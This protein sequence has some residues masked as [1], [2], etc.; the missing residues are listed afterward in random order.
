MED[1]RIKNSISEEQLSNLFTECFVWEPR[2]STL[3]LEK[4]SELINKVRLLDW[5]IEGNLTVDNKDIWAY[6]WM[7]VDK[8]PYEFENSITYEDFLD[9][10]KKVYPE[11]TWEEVR[12]LWNMFVSPAHQGKGYGNLLLKE[13]E[14]KVI[15]NWGKYII[16]STLKD[17]WFQNKLYEKNWYIN[18]RETEN[19]WHSLVFMIKGL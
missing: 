19:F 6:M 8:L 14:S 3:T 12:N 9:K 15:N 13:F 1:I 10:C 11:Y 18:F 2:N 17:E 7:K 5:Y 4:T 16:L